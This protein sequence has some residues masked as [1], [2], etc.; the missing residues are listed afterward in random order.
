MAQATDRERYGCR[1]LA[2]YLCELLARILHIG[3]VAGINRDP[4][5]FSFPSRTLS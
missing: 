5:A 1:D 2:G 3:G 4:K